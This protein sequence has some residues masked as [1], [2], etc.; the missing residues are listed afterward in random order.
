MTEQKEKN[1]QTSNLRK[2]LKCLE[3]QSKRQRKNKGQN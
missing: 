2:V 1:F 3:I